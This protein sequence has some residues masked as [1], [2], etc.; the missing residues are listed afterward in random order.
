M[1]VVVNG[2]EKDLP[3]ERITLIHKRDW[4]SRYKKFAELLNTCVPD[5]SHRTLIIWK[6]HTMHWYATPQA[7]AGASEAIELLIAENGWPARK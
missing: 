3:K 6:S 2:V 7:R 4:Y 1:I 5:E